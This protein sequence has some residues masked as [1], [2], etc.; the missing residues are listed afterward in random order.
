MVFTYPIIEPWLQTS[1]FSFLKFAVAIVDKLFLGNEQPSPENEER[2]IPC[3]YEKVH[4]R[5][6]PILIDPHF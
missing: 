1:R 5:R 2:S 6:I 4:N 3:E